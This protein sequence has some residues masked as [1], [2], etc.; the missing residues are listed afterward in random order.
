MPRF[1]LAVQNAPCIVRVVEIGDATSDDITLAIRRGIVLHPVSK[2]KVRY[3]TCVNTDRLIREY[4]GMCYRDERI[5]VYMRN[6][7][8]PNEIPAAMKAAL[9]VAYGGGWHEWEMD[10]GT[11]EL[12][13]SAGRVVNSDNWDELT[14]EQVINA[15][16]ETT[17][18]RLIEK[19]TPRE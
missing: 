16:V 9:K 13:T 3:F 8:T 4:A 10:D 19:V 7:S 17:T 12:R 15:P 14:A 18:Q 1:N 5:H 6:G 2:R 11:V